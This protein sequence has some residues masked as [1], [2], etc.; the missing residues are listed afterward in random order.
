MGQSKNG[1]VG[2]HFNEA[3]M[4]DE[5]MT[6][7]AARDGGRAS[8]LTISLLEDTKWY[9]GD[10]TRAEHWTT[11]K[12]QGC[13]AVQGGACPSP[14]PCTPGGGVIITSDFK[15]LA[16]CSKN[17]NG[18]NIERKYEDRVCT[19]G[20]SW[21][22]EDYELGHTYGGNC[23]VV[24]TKIKFIYNGQGPYSF[25]AKALAMPVE[26]EC[27]NGNSSYNLI[28]KKFDID[29]SGKKTGKDAVVTCKEA[30][31]QSFN[32][33]KASYKSE[34]ECFDPEVFC[35]S[36]FGADDAQSG[37]LCDSSCAANG[38]CQKAGMASG[39][40]DNGGDDNGGDDDGDDDGNDGGADDGNDGGDD[41][42]DAGGDAGGDDGGDDGAN[43]GGDGNDGDDGNDG[44]SDVKSMLDILS[45]KGYVC[46]KQ[47]AGKTIS[48]ELKRML[49]EAKNAGYTCTKSTSQER[50]QLSNYKVFN[51]KALAVSSEWACWCYDDYSRSRG[52]CK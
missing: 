38:R 20:K 46:K 17:A 43:D 27:N 45:K 52:A 39:G 21:G 6:P 10:Y 29:A 44:G 40:G 7:Y 37:P 49:A 48:E 18:C 41:G 16:S 32:T 1:I 33:A 22:I 36:R 23:A 25:G 26:A 31:Q 12:G 42:G 35:T 24:K 50:R 34:V 30:G 2:A 3:I 28:F 47:N 19:S 4:A 8:E 9:K 15:A 5:L 51:V 13:N 11:L 14:S